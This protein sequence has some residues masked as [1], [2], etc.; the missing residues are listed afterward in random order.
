MR[1]RKKTTPEILQRQFKYAYV[2]LRKAGMTANDLRLIL[3]H[4]EYQFRLVHEL[5][6][7]PGEDM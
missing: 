1:W 6:Q 7:L 3:G 4:A 2:Q 5:E